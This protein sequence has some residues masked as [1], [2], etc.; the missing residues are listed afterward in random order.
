MIYAPLDIYSDV[1]LRS[2]LRS[3]ARMLAEEIGGTTVFWGISWV[4]ISLVVVALVVRVGL[5]NEAE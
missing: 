3:D 2:Y 4:L 5:K 1:L